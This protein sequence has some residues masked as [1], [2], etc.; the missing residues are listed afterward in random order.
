MKLW[1]HIAILLTEKKSYLVEQT[2]DYPPNAN[3]IWGM[4]WW[5]K[6]HVLHRFGTVISSNYTMILDRFSEKIKWNKIIK[7][8]FCSNGE[9]ASSLEGYRIEWKKRL[10]VPLD[11]PQ[12]HTPSCFSPLKSRSS[13]CPGNISI[14]IC[15]YLLYFKKW[16]EDG[17][18]DFKSQIICCLKLVC[19][20]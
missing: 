18:R 5:W 10:N 14:L 17:L 19:L 15:Y 16:A 4:G 7:R 13:G 8:G 12:L 2:D 20:C 6:K 3:I 1:I 9:R 11:H